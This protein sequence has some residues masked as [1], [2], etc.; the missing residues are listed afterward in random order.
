MPRFILLAAGF[1][2]LGLG[3]TVVKGSLRAQVACTT[4][5]NVT[6]CYGT[7]SSGWPTSTTCV[8]YGNV[9]TCY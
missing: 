1:V 5:G 4:Y 3:C 8:T 6:T 7:N 9:T 2:V